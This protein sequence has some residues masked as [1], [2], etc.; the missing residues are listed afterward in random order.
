MGSHYLQ[1]FIGLYGLGMY[2]ACGWLIEKEPKHVVIIDSI[3]NRE[4]CY[5]TILCTSYCDNDTQRGVKHQDTLRFT[6]QSD[7]TYKRSKYVG[8]RC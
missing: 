6:T 7:E 8:N 5:M 3:F 4:L 1:Q 2:M